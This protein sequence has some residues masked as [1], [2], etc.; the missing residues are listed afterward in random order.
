[1]SL[2]CLWGKQYFLSK[3]FRVQIF[4][5][6]VRYSSTGNISSMIYMV[7]SQLSC[8]MLSKQ[9]FQLWVVEIM[10]TLMFLFFSFPYYWGKVWVGLGISTFSL[11]K[12]FFRRKIFVDRSSW[13]LGKRFVWLWKSKFCMSVR[14]IITNI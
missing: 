10:P 3:S 4:S 8:R 6:L 1:M 7:P 12:L 5:S 11:C 9:I 14:V 2:A 13:I